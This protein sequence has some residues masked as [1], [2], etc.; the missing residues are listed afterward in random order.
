MR[1][2]DRAP[3]P[4]RSIRAVLLR[5]LVV[6]LGLAAA[7][8]TAVGFLVLREIRKDLPPVDQ[9]AAYRPAVATQVYASG[10]ELVGEF[11]LEKRYLVPL[12]KIP[13]VVVQAINAADDSNYSH[14]RHIALQSI[15]RP[16]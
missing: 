10:G 1:R 12:D 6:T 2:R 4:R 7:V 14:H 3:R 16:S 8:A 15:A 11:F 13:R 9:L 5:I